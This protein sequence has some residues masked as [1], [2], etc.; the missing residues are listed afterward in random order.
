ML[1]APCPTIVRFATSFPINV[2]DHFCYRRYS[3]VLS[4]SIFRSS[5]VVVLCVIKFGHYAYSLADIKSCI[6]NFL[7]S[8]YDF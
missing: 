7:Y 4:F 3:T 1:T 5:E 6:V 2:S 8:F